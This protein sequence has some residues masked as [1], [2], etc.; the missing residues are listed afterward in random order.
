MMG[1]RVTQLLRDVERGAVS[2]E[3]ARNAL[4]GIDLSEEDYIKA[5]D[6]GVFNDPKPGTIVRASISPSRDSW[7]VI[8]VGLWGIT[9]TLFWAGTLSYG[10]Y[11][12]WDQQQLSFHLAMTLLTLIILGIVYLRFVMP[13][14]VVVKHRRNKY[15]TSNDTEAWK[16][17]E[18]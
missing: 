2:V 11:N 8:L 14:V 10:L 4:E 6:H 1:D 17:Y 13:D 3:D 18:V 15:I 12:K 9:W 7:L 16:Q 5:V